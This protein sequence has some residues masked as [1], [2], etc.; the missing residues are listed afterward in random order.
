MKRAYFAT[1][2]LPVWA[3]LVAA[4]P[5]AAEGKKIDAKADR[6]LREMSAYLAQLKAFSFQIDETFDEVQD[7]GQ[8]IQLGN[9]RTITV[10]RPNR[11]M[12]IAAG[13]TINRQFYYDGKTITLYSKAKKAYARVKAP[14]TI[15]AMLDAVHEK[16]GQGQPLA[17]FLFPD[18]YKILTEHVQSGAYVGLH[19]LGKV[20]CHHLAFRQ[21]GLDWQIWIED[22]DK[23]LPRKMVITHKREAGGP[24]YTA[25]LSKWDVNPKVKNALF[26]FEPPADARK[27]ALDTLTGTGEPEKKETAQ[28]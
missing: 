7:D 19:L 15:P 27:V 16:M 9:R 14:D 11:L 25:R 4:L 12:G 18:P 13:D 24:Q 5:A 8:K 23:P 17:D 28:K 1:A 3:L 2:A 20:K 6:Y 10:K 21:K 26:E 22:G